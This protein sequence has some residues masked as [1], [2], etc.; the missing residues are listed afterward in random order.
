MIWSDFERDKKYNKNKE[1]VLNPTL[2]IKCKRS[3][4]IGKIIT[5]STL[6]FTKIKIHK[7]EFSPFVVKIWYSLLFNLDKKSNTRMTHQ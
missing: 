2:D 6:K 1:E 5:L 4:F 7:I 3:F